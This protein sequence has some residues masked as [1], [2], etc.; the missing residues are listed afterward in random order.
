MTNLMNVRS[1]VEAGNPKKYLGCGWSSKKVPDIIEGKWK[2]ILKV[3]E[4]SHISY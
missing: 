2:V 4:K 1:I 3:F